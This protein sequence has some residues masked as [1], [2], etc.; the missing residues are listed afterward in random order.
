MK[1]LIPSLIA[2]TLTLCSTAEA[3]LRHNCHLFGGK[4]QCRMECAPPPCNRVCPSTCCSEPDQPTCYDSDGNP[5]PCS[6][7]QVSLED[8]VNDLREKVNRLEGAII[9]LGGSLPSDPQPTPTT[10]P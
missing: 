8:Q 6:A 1:L 4:R 7:A 9:R 2:A 5:V 10:Q 3:G